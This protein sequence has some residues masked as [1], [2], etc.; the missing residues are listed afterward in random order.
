MFSYFCKLLG[1]CNMREREPR[2]GNRI[3]AFFCRLVQIQPCVCLRHLSDSQTVFCFPFLLPL[4]FVDEI[5][6]Q[7][8]FVAKTAAGNVAIGGPWCTPDSLA[9]QRMI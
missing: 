7:Q 4:E 5:C 1:N 6:C 2:W 8:P 3:Q 9:A